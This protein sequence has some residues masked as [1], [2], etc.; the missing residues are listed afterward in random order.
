MSLTSLKPPVVTPNW[1][2]KIMPIWQDQI[3]TNPVVGV[4][5]KNAQRAAKTP[6]NLLLHRTAVRTKRGAF[7]P[8]DKF[9][10]SRQ[11]STRSGGI[12]WWKP[13][14]G[15]TVVAGHRRHPSFE[16][17]P[18][19]YG[20]VVRSV[21]HLVGVSRSGSAAPI[22]GQSSRNGRPRCGRHDA[23]GDSALFTHGDPFRRRK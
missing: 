10:S 14:S 6:L 22:S 4:R 11:I 23:C 16:D 9:M 7:L 20:F 3:S 1:R 15:L 21:R 13:P 2:S 17:G 5:E 12:S 18:R 19:P 8:T